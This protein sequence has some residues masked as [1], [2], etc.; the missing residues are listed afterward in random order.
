MTALKKSMECRGGGN[1][2]DWFFLAMAYWNLG[3]K[4][5]A[6]K[7]YDRAVEWMET[8]RPDDAEL[9]RFRAEAAAL[10]GISDSPE[11]DGKDE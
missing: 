8:K 10:L 1:S 9:A 6:R 7:W 3:E 5:E 11:E 4:E 2:F